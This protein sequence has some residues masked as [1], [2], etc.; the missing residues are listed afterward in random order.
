MRE[1][2]REGYERRKG[3]DIQYHSF[4]RQTGSMLDSAQPLS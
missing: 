1:R 3:S 4:K 2:E